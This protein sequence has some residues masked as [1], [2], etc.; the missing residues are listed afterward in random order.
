MT[1]TSSFGCVVI[2]MVTVSYC[3]LLMLLEEI[4]SLYFLHIITFEDFIEYT[5]IKRTLR[6]CDGE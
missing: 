1:L 3:C 6:V 4:E 2:I 5:N